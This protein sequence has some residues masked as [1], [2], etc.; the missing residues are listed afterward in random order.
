MGAKVTILHMP[1]SSNPKAREWQ[2]HLNRKI[3][4]A[5]E[6]IFFVAHSLGCI[7]LLNYLNSLN[8]ENIEFGGM[9]LVSGFVSKLDNLPELDGFINEEIDFEAIVN[10]TDNRVVIGA[11]DDPNV[12]HEH[13]KEMSKILEA[14]LVSLKAGGHLLGSN[15]YTQFP[16]VLNKI[17][18][19]I[20]QQYK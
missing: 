8:P 7:S 13:T 19:L 2:R 14:E 20:T 17:K 5:D 4:A 18:G 10:A 3:K 11:Q 15:G 16:L 9:V 6:N 1:N 12:P